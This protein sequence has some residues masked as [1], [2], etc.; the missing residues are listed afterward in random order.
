M[1]FKFL[2]YL[3]QLFA[4]CR[5][6]WTSLNGTPFNRRYN[7][8]DTSTTNRTNWVY[9][10]CQTVRHAPVIWGSSIY[11][12]CDTSLIKLS[13][14][15]LEWRKIFTSP[16]HATPAVSPVSGVVYVGDT[17]GSVWTVQS[18]GVAQEIFKGAAAISKGVLTSTDGRILYIV[19]DKFYA[20]FSNNGSV[21]WSTNHMNT[22][23]TPA[24]DSNGIVYL[25]LGDGFLTSFSS[26]G[27]IRWRRSLLGSTTGNP[28]IGINGYIY[29]AVARTDMNVLYGYNP[30]GN[31]ATTVQ[32]S[33]T[34]GNELTIDKGG[35]IRFVSGRTFYAID[36]NAIISNVSLD[37]SCFAACGSNNNV[38]LPCASKVLGTLWSLNFDKNTLY[39]SCSIDD[40][41]IVYVSTD[42]TIYAFSSTTPTPTNFPTT[43][44]PTDSPT[45]SPTNFPTTSGPTISPTIGPTDLPTTFGPTILPVVR[46]KKG[47][48][49][50]VLASAIIVPIVVILGCVVFV[51]LYRRKNTIQ[52]ESFPILTIVRK[53]E[54][55][56]TI[57]TQYQ[58][59]Y[60]DN[61]KIYY[62]HQEIE[63]MFKAKQAEHPQAPFDEQKD[64]HAN[65]NQQQEWYPTEP[66]AQPIEEWYPDENQ[67]ET[68]QEAPEEDYYNRSYEKRVEEE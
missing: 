36:T 39:G 57:A 1:L 4:I 40:T 23:M 3:I 46:E 55:R 65:E 10:G 29:I 28:A 14:G 24:I 16:I 53:D 48:S 44:G 66:E 25:S 15:A 51:I 26:A 63:E 45:I 64:W 30:N 59:Q 20:L 31:R 27:I 17:S 52:S 42:S 67:P 19:S 34:V 12:G 41:G 22:F 62:T 43:I 21:Y 38:I 54:L 58:Y 47:I 11:F 8:V 33:T 2:I 5:G 68:E 61:D 49:P 9:T 56:R 32:I 50:G 6:E 18:N 60:H 13:A 7:P 37:E 35:I